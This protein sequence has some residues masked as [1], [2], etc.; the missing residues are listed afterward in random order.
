VDSKCSHSHDVVRF[1]A[2]HRVADRLANVAAMVAGAFAPL[3]AAHAK[4]MAERDAARLDKV[5]DSLEVW[6]PTCWPPKRSL[7]PGRRRPSPA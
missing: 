4:A 7:R 2:A 1:G 6:A 5:A 3:F